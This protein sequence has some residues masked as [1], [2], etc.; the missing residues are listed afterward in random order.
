MKIRR[1]GVKVSL[2][3]TIMIAVIIGLTI[4]IVWSQTDVLV[5]DVATR[6]AEAANHS[7]RIT[8]DELKQ[9]ALTRAEIIANSDEVAKAIQN[10]N[11]Y[12]LKESVTNIKTGLDLVMIYDIEGNLLVSTVV[13]IDQNTFNNR[14]EILNTISTI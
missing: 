10:N 1:L 14:A 6:N 9:E 8:I 4:I 13:D 2:I 5:N 11:H 3:V 12:A 7:L